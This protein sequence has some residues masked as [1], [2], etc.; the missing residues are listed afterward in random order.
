MQ[1]L[2]RNNDAIVD[3]VEGVIEAFLEPVDCELRHIFT[4]GL[5][6][7]QIT[8]PKG[9]TLTS[10]IHNTCHPFTISKGKVSVWIDAENEQVLEAP[11]TGITYPGT[12]RV[13]Y[14]HEEVIWTTYHPTDIV[15]EGNEPEDIEAAVQKIG[16]LIIEP[17]QNLLLQQSKKEELWHG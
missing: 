12:R 2:I 15:P 10:L 1:Q 16:D 7:R 4:P 13:L 9:T 14:T 8:I 17:H 6:A 11:Y 3:L 5:Y